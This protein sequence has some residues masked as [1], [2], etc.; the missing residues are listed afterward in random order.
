[1]SAHTRTEPRTI[2][3]DRPTMIRA[4]AAGGA[5]LLVLVLVLART[6]G[7]DEPAATA[8]L[9][10]SG[11]TSTT[12][13]P[14]VDPLA[15]LG[16]LNPTAAALVGPD[17]DARRE[18]A[19]R[20]SEVMTTAGRDQCSLVLGATQGG[21]WELSTNLGPA[22]PVPLFAGCPWPTSTTAVPVPSVTTAAAVAAES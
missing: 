7:G 17:I 14:A 5:A 11:P 12:E 4:A 20:A 2:T 15:N 18:L 1:M 8:P 3:L 13:A 21:S 6:A 16:V 10:L 19:R 9:V 22:H